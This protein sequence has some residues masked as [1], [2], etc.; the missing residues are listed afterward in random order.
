ML[1]QTIVLGVLLTLG[2]AQPPRRERVHLNQSWVFQ[3]WE[4]NLDGIVYDK[5][6]DTPG[7][8]VV[9]KPWIL[10]SANEF[11]RDPA[12]HYK[13]PS[14]K[15]NVNIPFMSINYNDSTWERVEVPHDWA[16]K[17]PFYTGDGVIVGGGMGRLPIHGIGWY[18][19]KFVIYPEDDDKKI[20]LDIDGA[21]SYAMVW[22][23]DNLV[24]GWPFGY[25]SF[26]VDLTPHVK[27]GGYNQLAIRLDNPVQSSR[28]YPGGGLYRNVWMTKVDETH[29]AHWG[30]FVTTEGATAEKATVQLSVQV[31]NSGQTAR[32]VQVL[33]DV[34]YFDPKTHKPG[35]IVGSF[36]PQTLTISA[37]QKWT[38]N[39]S[40]T[41]QNPQLWGPPPSQTP[42]LHVAL[43]RLVVGN[44]TVDTYSTRFGIRAL[45]ATGTGLFVNGQR[46]YLQGVNQHHDLGAL[47]GAFNRRAAQ[48]QFEILAEMGVNALRMAHNPPAPELLDLADEMG[49]LVI[50]ES[51][52]CWAKS[53]NPNDFHLIFSDWA[54]ADMRSMMRRDR[55]HPSIF[56]WSTGNEVGEQTDDTAPIA[57]ALT[58]IVHSEDPTRGSTASMNVAK[59]H[60]PFAA[61][62]DVLSINYQGEG[63]RD[64]GPYAPFPG[65]RT[66]PIYG[67]FHEAF[68][69]A[70][71]LTS[72]SAATLSTRGTYFFPVANLSS[73]PQVDLPNAN[74][75]ANWARTY[76]YTSS[77]PTLRQVS[78]HDLY[79]TPFGAS[80]DKV[81]RTQDANP[82]VG[83]EFVWTGFDYLGEPTPYYTARSSYFGIVDL[84]GFKKDRFWL[85]Q[86]RWRPEVKSVRIV[87]HWNWQGKREGQ[88]TA[89]HAYSSADE[90]ELWV[91]GVSMGK[92]VRKNGE[93]YR[94]RWDEVV[95]QPG[96]VKLVAW[97]GGQEWAMSVLKTTGKPAALRVTADR[98][99]IEGDGDDLAFLTVEVVD[100]EGLVVPDAGNTVVFAVQGKGQLLATDNGDPYDM[101]AFPSKERKAFSGMA[102]GIV[103]AKVGMGGSF[104]VTV[105]STGLVGANVTITVR[106]VDQ[107]ECDRS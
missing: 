63:I 61:A 5:R 97:K 43:T 46:I 80:P 100:A 75:D 53:K 58:A 39:A 7:D 48:R 26:R 23:N 94:F 14:T 101:V 83:G 45:N 1:L 82:F 65:T 10:P 73:A 15:P 67:P 2:A 44:E 40:L 6:Q 52:D 84:A 25:N 103:R 105:T 81:F 59:P 24:G 35:A 91:N 29:V 93:D 50:D 69:S 33:T 99:E 66:P 8:A 98:A 16:V 36:P 74:L 68:P 60:H 9:L 79:S 32:T 47:G 37:G 55:N 30:T 106:C 38:A 64:T 19:R 89:L 54:E 27:M 86:S 77:S 95:Y 107:W 13:L 56:A 20:Y 18:R 51:F 62:L 104:A 22:I 90:A 34:H 72:E 87:G 76:N 92:R 41:V 70:L 11:I 96:E 42:H 88:V 31:E 85:Y 102:L 17:G 49:F 3:R 21:M 57:K 12:K 4:K 78:S 28:W 71:L